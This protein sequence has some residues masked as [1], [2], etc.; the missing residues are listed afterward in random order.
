EDGIRAGHVTGV[1]TCALPI[2][3]VK[4]PGMSRPI[5]RSPTSILAS[6]AIPGVELAGRCVG[7][8]GVASARSAPHNARDAH[9]ARIPLGGAGEIG[10]ASCRERVEVPWHDGCI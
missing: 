9:H 5:T 1:Q 7:L 8:Q 2:L 6:S 4:M 3:T 10:R